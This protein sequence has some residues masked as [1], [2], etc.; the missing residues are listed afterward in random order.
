MAVKVEQGLLACHVQRPD[1]CPGVGK[2]GSKQ[3]GMGAGGLI[4]SAV[5]T[6]PYVLCH[7]EQGCRCVLS[8]RKGDEG[9]EDRFVAHPSVSGGGAFCLG[10]WR[11]LSQGAE[12]SV[13]GGGA[14]CL[15]KRSLFL[16]LGWKQFT[17]EM[18]DF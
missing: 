7:Y 14:F 8:K 18:S 13:S 10:R 12:P 11:L 3:A 15:R 1:F 16:E 6:Y 5:H 9:L 2:E 4:Y 17:A